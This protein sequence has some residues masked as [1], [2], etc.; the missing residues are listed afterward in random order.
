MSTKVEQASAST[1]WLDELG[2][3]LARH[4]GMGLGPMSPR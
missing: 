2:A 1:G 4:S 3:L